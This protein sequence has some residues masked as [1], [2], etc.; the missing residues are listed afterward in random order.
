MVKVRQ[1][2]CNVNFYKN[3]G[4]YSKCIAIKNKKWLMEK[5]LGCKVFNDPIG[6][7]IDKSC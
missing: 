6:F 5:L 3:H 4:I 2:F 1:K 7:Q